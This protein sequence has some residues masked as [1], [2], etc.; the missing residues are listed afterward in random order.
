MVTLKMFLIKDYQSS[1]VNVKIKVIIP[2]RASV[3]IVAFVVVHA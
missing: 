3:P 1:Y 2:F